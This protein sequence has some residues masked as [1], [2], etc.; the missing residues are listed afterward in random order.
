[1]TAAALLTGALAAV[2]GYGVGFVHF[3]TLR[4]V[5]EMLVAGRGAA[6]ALQAGRLAALAAF[7]TL[8]ALAG[9]AALLGAT[10]GL[11]AGRARA[12]RGEAG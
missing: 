5:A 9:S 4:R 12:L 1:M 6:A 7:L 8:C 10:A 3:R 11:M 2:A